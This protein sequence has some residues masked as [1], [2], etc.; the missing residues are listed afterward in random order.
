[1]C[2]RG[3]SRGGRLEQAGKKCLNRERWRL[4]CHGHPL[5]DIPGGSKASER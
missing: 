4:L 5:G 2:E 1:M 3:A